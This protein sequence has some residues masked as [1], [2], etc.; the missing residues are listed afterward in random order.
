MSF[1]RQ[2]SDPEFSDILN[3]IRKGKQTKEDEYKI[4]QLNNT[5]TSNWLYVPIKLYPMNETATVASK[6]V[7][8]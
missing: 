6:E 5:D 2:S 8:E 4:E 1:V 7:I 3:R